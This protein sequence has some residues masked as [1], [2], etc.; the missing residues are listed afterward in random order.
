M[1]ETPDDPID[2]HGYTLTREQVTFLTLII[3]TG[4]GPL[5]ALRAMGRS[6]RGL[7]AWKKDD[8]FAKVYTEIAKPMLALHR[9]EESHEVLIEAGKD[10][11][12]LAGDD[13]KKASALSNLARSRADFKFR[14]A[15]R[16]APKEWG[17][18]T[19]VE[20]TVEHQAIVF[21]PQLAPL[22][23]APVRAVLG[24]GAPDIPQLPAVVDHAEASR[25]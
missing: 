14:A 19:Q 3:E 17:P 24:E 9:A 6:T 18:K 12:N 25:P 8:T 4:V 22:P 16:L 2:F 20:G 21:L 23:A 11:M 13:V 7:V 15:E 1:A 10:I 5:A